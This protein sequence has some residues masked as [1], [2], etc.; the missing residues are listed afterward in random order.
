MERKGYFISFEGTDGCG[1]GTQIEK[2]KNY[3]EAKEIDAVFTREPGGVETADK[4]RAFVK[5]PE[6]DDIDELS[7]FLLISAGRNLH[8]KQK[9]KPALETGKIVVTDRYVDSCFAYQGY[10]GGLDLKMIKDVTNQVIQGIMPDI[11]FF[12]SLD[13]STSLERNKGLDDK[14]DKF[15]LKGASFQENVRNGFLQ[16][17]EEDP[18]RWVVIDASLSREEIFDII[19]SELEKRGVIKC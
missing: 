10:A 3:F 7:D 5:D 4:I 16:M 6:N 11:T 9:I 13:G 2:L 12:L 15:E 17:V 1:K 14:V 19:I 18:N 8:V